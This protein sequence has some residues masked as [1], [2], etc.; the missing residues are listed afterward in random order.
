[1]AGATVSGGMW[2]ISGDLNVGYAGNGTLNVNGG[3]VTNQA[4]MI[5]S[6][7]GSVGTATVSSGTWAN[8]GDLNVGRLG[9]GTLTMTGGL[10]SVG[11][12]LST[13]TFGA[14]NLNSGGT[15]QIGTGGT[16]GVLG[17]SALTNNGTLVFSRSTASTYSGVL[18]GSGALVK[19]GAGTLTLSG[20]NS[21]TGATIVSAGTLQMGS[22]NALGI[23]VPLTVNAGTLDLNGF[24]V[25]VGAFSGSSGA[26]IT[27]S[28]SGAVTLTTSSAADSTFGGA[29]QD[30]AGTAALY[31]EGAGT[32]TLSG[33]NSYT[34]ATT[35][36][37]GT[38]AVTSGG[39]INHGG[40]NL[41]VGLFGTATLN[42]TG[43]RVTNADGSLGSYAGSVGTATVSSGT[44]ANTGDLVVGNS[45]TGTL[46]MT[47]GLVSVGG[48]LSQGNFGTINLNSG[49]TLQIGTGGTGGVLGV[50]T[51]TN[52]GTLIFNRSDASTYAGIISG[53]G[54]LTK[55]GAGTLT[56]SGSNSYTGATTVSAGELKVNGSTGTGAMTIASD[57]TLSGTG[58]IGGNTTIS[59]THTPGNSPGVQTFS[60]DLTYVSAGLT[61]PKVFWELAANTISNSP[62]EYD[63]IVV[64]GNL[65]FSSATSFDLAFG[66]SGSTV[67]WSN[68]L[69]ATDEQ[70]TIYSVSG[71]LSG[72]SNLQL[73][74]SDWL[75]SLGNSFNSLLAGSTFSL[76]QIGQDVVLKYTAAQAAVPEIDPASCG[77]ALA[78]LIG[79]FGLIERRARRRSGRSITG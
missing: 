19:D 64:G 41:N 69:W 54:A 16:G 12:T 68:A 40:A 47:G 59:G 10:V 79:S 60:S 28:T 7:A 29:I 33:S 67:D 17:V 36:N 72:F 61:G 42:V 71:S 35:V 27:S 8:S 48:T 65:A 30:G 2:A 56:L 18:S 4:S 44:W 45:G 39:A 3:L 37:G 1:M 55:Q 70:W 76:L 26:I 32:L 6:Y 49:G 5:G 53:S 73:T 11:G 9:T 51:L 13:G 77:S 62:T 63:Q 21:Y 14:I 31:K 57:A 46:T 24:R 20:S 38:L 23:G 74:T 22:R 34:G 25:A 50:S 66:S 52:N 15:L 78:L 75:D 43:G 58:T